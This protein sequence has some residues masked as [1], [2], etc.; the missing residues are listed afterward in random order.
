MTLIDKWLV[1][2]FTFVAMLSVGTEC[3]AAG[4]AGECLTQLELKAMEDSFWAHYPSAEEFSSYAAP[5]M[6]IAT[7]VVDVAKI[8]SEQRTGSGR[9]V[10]LASFLA[11]HP[12]HF[13]S[14]KTKHQPTYLYY[15][16]RERSVDSMRASHEYPVGQCVSMFRFESD[17][18]SCVAGQR[19]R[20]LSLTFIKEFNQT[21]L[22]GAQVAMEAC[23]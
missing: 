7:N 15:V 8:N 20:V 17:D 11:E 23:Q 13:L 6:D 19:L 4:S 5:D 1:S 2:T 18:K 12:E 14:F 22:Q 16:G 3:F 9:A 21:R 10:Q